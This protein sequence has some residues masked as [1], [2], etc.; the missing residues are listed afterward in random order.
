MDS[1]HDAPGEPRTGDPA[2]NPGPTHDKALPGRDT[3]T[4]PEGRASAGN[5]Q[6]NCTAPDAETLR[7]EIPEAMRVARRWLVWRME[8]NADPTKKPRKVPF[9]LSGQHRNGKL[10]TAA[11]LAK[12]GTFDAMLAA[13]ATGRYTG[14]GFALGSDGG[15]GV[16]QGIDLDHTDERPELAALIDQLPG[17]VERSPSGTG[18]HAIG[19]GPAVP[20]MGSNASGIE[21][22]SGGRYFTVTGDAIGGDIADLAPFIVGTL[23][24]LHGTRAT[25][26]QGQ[27]PTAPTETAD[28]QTIRDLRSALLHLR[29]DDRALW[30]KIGLA[31]KGLG[32]AGR[33][34]WL[35]WSATSEK[36]DAADASRTW[37]TF[38]PTQTGFRAVFTAAQAAGWVNPARGRRPRPDGPPPPEPD[39]PA[40][41]NGPPPCEPN[42]DFSA[43][44][45]RLAALH[46]I[47]YDRG[48][49]AEAKA[50]GIRVGTLD[51]EVS[52]ARGHA[53]N[54][55]D[56]MAVVEN[57]EP[58]EEPVS[59]L[60]LAEAV[61]ADF[62]RYV[63]A[64]QEALDTLTV[65]TLGTYVYDVFQIW[66]KAFLSSPER[67]CGKSTTLTVI[68][69]N[70]SRALMAS[71]IS[72]SALFRAVDLW[73]PSLILD[74][75][76]RLPKDNEDLIAVINAGHMRRTAVIIRNVPVGDSY[77]PR[78]FSVWAPMVLAAIGRMA[79]TIMD[80]SIV[81]PMRRKLP[82]ETSAKVPP[83]LFER[84][85]DRRRQC[86]R[87][88][89]DATI[90]LAEARVTL[91][92]HGNDRALDN[93]TPLYA[94]AKTLG[95]DWPA[96]I[97]HAFAHLAVADGDQDET[98]GPMLLGDVRSVFE[99][100][101]TSKIWSA[102]LVAALV[103][104]EDRPW[105]E[106]KR[107]KPMTQNSLSRLLAPYK[108]RS[109]NVRIGPT[110]ARGYTL[111]DFRDTFG[112]YLTTAPPPAP[113]NRSA[114]PLHPSNGAGSS[115]FQTATL[116]LDV[117]DG[118]DREASNGAGCSSVANE[119]PEH[120]ERRPVAPA[121][122]TAEVF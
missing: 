33:G 75:A 27:H 29:A 62:M 25:A 116:N 122:D 90:A 47:E 8:P 34:L 119:N 103:A 9:Y 2:C 63:I 11:D 42:E 78:K 110:V 40:P 31:L 69:A 38:R 30:V 112:R 20:A 12:L 53:T 101:R 23:A 26:P 79:D 16:W 17:Y 37:E 48:R 93:W 111:D 82:H 15:P 97:S 65:W 114:T 24:P 83:D 13:L 68:E 5:R 88:A 21:T 52:K 81:I 76:D 109:G 35:D 102:D 10:D 56:D 50:L 44:V 1:Y 18:V 41:D 107:G 115:D 66:A 96:R 77:E 91:P 106:W 60:A 43:T 54:G 89:L 7:T 94:I 100:K 72:A 70:V 45:A 95:G 67:R 105:C 46:P 84:C 22:Y 118:K 39:D 71:S 51:R 28:A 49:D 6:D 4:G 59:G 74:E 73:R 104:M 14:P 64:D 85:L 87:W 108:V 121:D 113:P 58:W 36:F 92:A 32:D 117:A 61:R 86:L 3:G 98:A 99:D 57:L 19:Y 120:W 55:S 80:R